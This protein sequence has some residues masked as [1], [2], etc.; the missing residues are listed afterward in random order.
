MTD[1]KVYTLEEVADIL[2]LSK[3]T[4]YQYLQTGKLK[5]VKLGKAWR[6]SAENLRDFLSGGTQ[7]K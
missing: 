5:G 6:I 1:I 2:K 4:V 3:R 7:D